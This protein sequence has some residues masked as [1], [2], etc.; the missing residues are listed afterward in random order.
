MECFP[1]PRGPLPPAIGVV[2]GWRI[3]SYFGGRIDP[4]NGRPG[5]HGGMDLAHAACHGEKIFACCSGRVTQGWDNSGGG[6]WT[7]LW[8]DDGCRWGYGHASAYAQPSLNGH[9]VAAGTLL[10]YIGTSGGSTGAHLHLAYAR[11]PGTIYS[12]PYNELVEAARAGRFP[13]GAPA[14]P[15]TIGGEEPVTRDDIKAIAIETVAL[16]VNQRGDGPA[17]NLTQLHNELL[18]VPEA[19]S[20]RTTDLLTNQH[21]DGPEANLTEILSRLQRIEADVL[22]LTPPA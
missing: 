22:A 8:G 15:Q 5:N 18:G 1:L 14:P 2:G 13:G 7:N 17:A 11:P 16:L 20:Q 6:W 19:T 12:D 3:T 4:L 9:H 10:A 21:G